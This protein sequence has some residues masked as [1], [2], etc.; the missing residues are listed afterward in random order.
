[1]AP[2][3]SIHSFNTLHMPQIVLLQDFSQ[4]V[5]SS[6]F[7]C[8]LLKGSI[9]HYRNSYSFLKSQ[10]KAVTLS[11]EF[12]GRNYFTAPWRIYRSHNCYETVN[13]IN[14]WEEVCQLLAL[15]ITHPQVPSWFFKFKP[16]KELKSTVILSNIFSWVSK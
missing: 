14:S 4:S 9:F 11:F 13:S 7:T 3:I 1:M 2:C 8:S 15:F 5:S 6:T 16:H 12:S 10:L